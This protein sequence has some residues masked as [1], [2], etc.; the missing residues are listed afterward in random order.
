MLPPKKGKGKLAAQVQ[1]SL[2]NPE[3]SVL[4]TASPSLPIPPAPLA[5]DTASHTMGDYD[6]TPKVSSAPPSL[7]P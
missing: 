1:N 5:Q 3:A 4:P 6:L 7:K 2:L